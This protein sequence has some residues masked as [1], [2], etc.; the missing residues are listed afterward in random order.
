VSECVHTTDSDAG[1][2]IF[3]LNVSRDMYVYTYF[4]IYD[5]NS[6]RVNVYIDVDVDCARGAVGRVGKGVPSGGRLA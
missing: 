2:L 6:N 3:R 1:G 4:W 5:P